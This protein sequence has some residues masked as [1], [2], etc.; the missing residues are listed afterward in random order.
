MQI[1]NTIKLQQPEDIN[2]K[3]FKIDRVMAFVSCVSTLAHFVRERSRK[4]VIIVS[5]SKF[6]YEAVRSAYFCYLNEKYGR[7]D[8]DGRSIQDMH[9]DFKERYLL[10]ILTR[11]NKEFAD[12]VLRETKDGIT[13]NMVIKLL[14]IADGS[15]CTTKIL[16]EYFQIVQENEH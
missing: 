4:H 7:A 2:S 15:I 12:L 3:L 8:H 13:S 6:K 14:S 1:G 11:E 5:E 16:K 9:M 10:P